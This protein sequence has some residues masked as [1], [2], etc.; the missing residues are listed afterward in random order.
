[1]SA[2]SNLT[3]ALGVLDEK[4]QSLQAMTQANQFLVDAL[5]EK[6]PVLKA[7]DAEGA[8]GFLRQSA[9][10]RFGEDENY[11]EVLALLEQILAPRQSAD[12]IPFPSR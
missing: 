1:M 8:R 10:A 2:N 3:T 4:L 12:I 9:R 5:R 7:L 11:E 6:E